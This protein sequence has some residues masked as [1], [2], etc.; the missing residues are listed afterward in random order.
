MKKCKFEIFLK[1]PKDTKEIPKGNGVMEWGQACILAFL[2][3]CKYA[4]TVKN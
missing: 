1:G 2:S 3:K 4:V